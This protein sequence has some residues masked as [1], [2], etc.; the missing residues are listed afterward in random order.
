MARNELPAR[1]ALLV[2][3]LQLEGHG[4][5]DGVYLLTP[6][7]RMYES[8]YRQCVADYFKHGWPVPYA[9]AESVGLTRKSSQGP[10]IGMIG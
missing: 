4:L 7:M 9:D 2:D 10:V 3:A 6:G 5:K 1:K 8:A